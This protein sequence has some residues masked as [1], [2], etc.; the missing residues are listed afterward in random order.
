MDSS[1]KRMITVGK[2]AFNKQDYETAERCIK[3][4]IKKKAVFPDLYNMLG[5]IYHERGKYGLAHKAFEKA[6]ELNPNYTE[7]SLNLSVTYNDLGKY[8]EA[9]AGYTKAKKASTLE[10]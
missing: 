9:K 4:V 10:P 1:I 3:D 7:A 2:E 6:L 8:T 5:L